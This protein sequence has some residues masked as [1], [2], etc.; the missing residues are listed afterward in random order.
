MRNFQS[1]G[2]LQ[3][4]FTGGNAEVVAVDSRVSRSCSEV[5]R[6]GWWPPAVP[7]CGCSVVGT[8]TSKDDETELSKY[9]RTNA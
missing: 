4:K 3:V 1:T 9:K 8:A 6:V 5:L 7:P 2:T